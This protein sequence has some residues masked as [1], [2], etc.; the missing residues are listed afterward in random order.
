MADRYQ[1][2]PFPVG[3]NYGRDDHRAPAKGEGDPLAE[4]AR[5]IGQ[6]DPFGNFGRDTHAAPAPVP[7]HREDHYEDQE[8]PLDDDV[9]AGPPPWMQ[10]RMV[11]QPPQQDFEPA[12]HPV[13][14]RAAVYP[15]NPSHFQHAQQDSYQTDS[16]RYDDALFGHVPDQQGGHDGRYAD[17]QYPDER[18]GYQDS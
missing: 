14:R 9:P 8:P 6:T 4:L 13:L 1:D 7:A 2:R 3:D 10:K 17:E 5:L 16:G 11:Q 12:P 15:D 18:Y